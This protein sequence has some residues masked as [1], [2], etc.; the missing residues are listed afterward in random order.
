LLPKLLALQEVSIARGCV[1]Y[2]KLVIGRLLGISR[3]ER[4]TM[5]LLE[6][7]QESQDSF[8]RA[9][10]LLI[11]PSPTASNMRSSQHLGQYM[12]LKQLIQQAVDAPGAV[13]FGCQLER[14]P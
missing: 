9:S 1:L 8:Q 14:F 11:S 3:P 6:L 7:M 10:W 13:A 4:T 5:F 12:R 2:E